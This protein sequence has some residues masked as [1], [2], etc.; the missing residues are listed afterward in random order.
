M[1]RLRLPSRRDRNED[2]YV[3]VV[4][5]ILFS[6]IL[7][8]LAAVGVDTARW[9]VELERA[10][11]AAD[12][13]AMAG[14]VYLPHNLPMA[15]TTARE[16]AR[17][18]GFDDADPDVDVQVDFGDRR[19]QLEVVISS[20]VDNQ[21]GAAI[22][23]ETATINRQAVADYTSPAPMGSPCNVFGNEPPGGNNLTSGVGASGPRGS[24]IPAAYSASGICK[25][26]PNFWAAVEGPETDKQQGDRYSTAPCTLR[27][28]SGKLP[29]GC[30][31]SVN[32][33][34]TFPEGYFFT[35]KVPEG[36]ESSPVTLQLYDPAYVSTGASCESMPNLDGSNYL[37]NLNPYV[38]TAGSSRS[39]DVYDAY[40]RYTRPRSV[41]SGYESYARRF[42]SG[43]SQ[44]GRATTS[45]GN[46][47]TAPVTS[48][49]V[50]AANDAQDPTTGVPYSGCTA[51][52][53]GQ[54]DPPT[55]TD[56]RQ[57]NS[58]GSN[59]SGY[60]AATAQVFHQWVTLCTFTPTEA[61]D[62]Y[63]Q[64]RTNV[65][66]PGS[67]GAHERYVCGRSVC[68]RDRPG[69]FRYNGNTAVHA[70]VGTLTHGEGVNAFGIRAISAAADQISVS[71]W[72]RMPM[73]QN[74]PDSTAS[75]NL[76]RVLPAAAGQSIAFEFYDVADGADDEGTV[77]V[78]PPLTEDDEEQGPFDDC[79][80]ALNDDDF[81]E[82]QGCQVG[83]TNS[84]NNGQVQRMR[85]PIPETYTCDDDV[86][87][88]CWFRVDI[89]LNGDISDFTTWDARLEGDPV[90][91]IE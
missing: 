25:S 43:D 4:V 61:G 33:E 40:L 68:E 38:T 42:C 1:T 60:K 81:E 19:S 44:P 70:R 29:Y 58:N 30:S 72:S 21:F 90:R 69:T 59:N 57:K 87:T 84:D 52:F 89:S 71:G 55:V 36:A 62:H 3:A 11:R 32:S 35:I 6:S 80:A 39:L 23:V 86:L 14:V 22:G 28:T 63:L 15:I 37:T 31:G 75:F 26:E 13:A 65:P 8:V 64:V 88:G 91:L 10:Q 66:L 76:L 16:S 20:T 7:L 12:A 45:P 2:G 5:A 24:Q 9:Y 41:Q 27:S 82:L 48:F 18:N 78:V 67:V 50:R 51:Q 56:L 73:L 47:L 34:A 85:I 49:A 77:T 54:Q 53:S 83:V 74:V 46:R 17:L 79:T